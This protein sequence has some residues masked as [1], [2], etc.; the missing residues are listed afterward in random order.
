MINF[1]NVISVIIWYHDDKLLRASE[2]VKIVIKD[3]KTSVTIKKTTSEDEGNYI[4]KATSEI[5]VAVTKA[6][7][8]II[9]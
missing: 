5:G 6:N 3:N 2:N 7:L 4:C 1:K 8:T 9:G